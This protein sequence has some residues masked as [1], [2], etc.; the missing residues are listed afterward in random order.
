MTYVRTGVQ[1]LLWCMLL[2]NFSEAAERTRVSDFALLG[3]NLRRAN[4]CNSVVV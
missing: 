3:M 4:V 2:C 1:S